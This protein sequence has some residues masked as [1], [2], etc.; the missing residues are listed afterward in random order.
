MLTKSFLVYATNILTIKIY[1]PLIWFIKM[2]NIL[3][4][5]VLPDPLTPN[6]TDFFSLSN[7]Q[8]DISQSITTKTIFIR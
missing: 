8:T 7:R 1:V 4:R 6:K 5:V 2:T 3:A